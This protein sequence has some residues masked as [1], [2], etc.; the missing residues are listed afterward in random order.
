MNGVTWFGH[1]CVVIE[2]DNTRLATDPVLGRRVA[3]LMREVEIPVSALGHIDGLLI[4]HVHLDH[5][6]TASLRGFDRTL[7]VVVP[8]HAGSI[9]RR[10]GFQR[11]HEVMPG[12]S[13]VLHNVRIDV[14]HAEHGKVRRYLRASSSALGFV[15]RGSHDIYF[16]GDTDLFGQM[17]DLRPLDVALLPV[18]GWGPRLPAGHLDPVRAAEALTLLEP[19]AA[20]PIHWGTY[21]PAFGRASETHPAETFRA[22]ASL[23]APSVRVVV[24]GLGESLY[25]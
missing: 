12:E 6:D 24:L 20:V 21:G 15:V 22:A 8:R 11:V 5:L 4:S 14:T 13:L 7:P 17:E 18:S 9:L 10:R 19:R 2:V 25:L 23:L 3:H 1:S 16:A